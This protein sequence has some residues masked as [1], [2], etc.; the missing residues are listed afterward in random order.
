MRRTTK[1][2]EEIQNTKNKIQCWS[3]ELKTTNKRG[4]E[5]TKEILCFSLGEVHWKNVYD[6]LKINNQEY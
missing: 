3:I 5:R 4:R 1:D 6:E 2:Q